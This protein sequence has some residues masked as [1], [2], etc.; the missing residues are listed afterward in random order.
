MSGNINGLVFHPCTRR[1]V[2]KK[3]VPSPIILGADGAGNKSTA[4]IWADII[5]YAFHALGAERTFIAT[6]ARIKRLGR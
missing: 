6:D 1:I 4:T 2:T 3:I 5:Q